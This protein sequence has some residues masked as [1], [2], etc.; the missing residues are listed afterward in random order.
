MSAPAKTL[1]ATQ[2]LASG[3]LSYSSPTSLQE[4]ELSNVGLHFS[5]AITQVLTISIVNRATPAV[6]DY[7]LHKHT[8]PAGTTDY[9]WAPDARWLVTRDQQVKVEVANSGTPVSI[10][11]MSLNIVSE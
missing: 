1:I 2:N 8:L 4:F 7:V 11:G 9:A 3:P 6:Y 5:A 10:A